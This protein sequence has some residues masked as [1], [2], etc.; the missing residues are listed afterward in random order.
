MATTLFRDQPVHTVGDLPAV[1]S[2]APDFTLL[3]ADLAPV[4]LRDL[5]GR[6]VVLV[7]HNMSV[8]SELTDRITVLQYGSVLAS[9]KYDDVRRDP[10]VIEAYLGEE[11]HA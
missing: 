4:S 8:V 1:G 3:G 5:R 9:G 6:T 7:E 11:G 2:S 10:R